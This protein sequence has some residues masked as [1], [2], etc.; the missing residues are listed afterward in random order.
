MNFAPQAAHIRRM[1]AADLDRVIEIADRLKDAPHWPRSAYRDAV[2]AETAPA[3][4]ALVAEDPVT[5]ALAGFAV[6]SLLPPQAEL[7]IIAV[8]SQ[9]QRR[10]LAQQLF[11]GL[12]A[13]LR[14]NQVT[15][16]ILEVRASNQPALGLYR[17]LGFV[18]TGYRP[19]YY[20]DP[21]EDA[22]LM[23]LGL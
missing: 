17:K 19:A 2:D 10:G 15:E 23:R 1:T 8:A 16:V 9:F 13:E 5:S 12:A 6:A 11:A 4:I 7:E 18:G 22:V 14:A 20:P 3:R 21:Q